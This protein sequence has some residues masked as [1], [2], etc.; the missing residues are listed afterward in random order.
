M[1][2]QQYCNEEEFDENIDAVHLMR[3]KE[4]MMTNQQLI[5]DAMPQRPKCSISPINAST[6]EEDDSNSLLVQSS[7]TLVRPQPQL[8]TAIQSPSLYIMPTFLNIQST[9]HKPHQKR[10]FLLNK[11]NFHSISDLATSSSSSSSSS[12]FSPYNSSQSTSSVS[13][14]DMSS[15]QHINQSI[16]QI[17]NYS[18]VSLE[19]TNLFSNNNKENQFMASLPQP[20]D[21]LHPNVSIMSIVLD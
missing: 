2:R 15:Y 11:T 12:S 10:N 7:P 13:F 20:L 4:F 21:F 14:N 6:T 17:V 9:P 18:T 8:A 16:P 5:S 3:I 19:E 1:K